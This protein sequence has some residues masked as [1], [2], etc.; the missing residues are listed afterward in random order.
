MRTDTLHRTPRVIIGVAL[1]MITP[2]ALAQN[3]DETAIGTAD[4]VLAEP[5]LP[6]PDTQPCVVHLFQDE[7]FGAKG[8]NKR[9]DSLPHKYTY[10]PPADCQGPWS[11]VVLEADFSVD[12]GSQYDRTASIWLDGVNIYFGTTQEPV[13][14]YGPDWHIERDLTDYSALLRKPGKGAARINNWVDPRH[15]SKIHLDAKLVFYPANAQFPAPRTADQVVALNTKNA[16]AKLQTG[17]QTLA[18]T[19]TFPRDVTRAYLDVLAQ[20]QFHDEYWFTCMPKKYVKRTM[21]FAIP[22]GYLGAPKIPEACAGGNFREAEVSIDG[23]PAGLAPIFPWIYTGGLDRLL[24][25]PSASVQT[26]NFLPYRVDLSPFAGELADGQPHKVSVR[27]IGANQYFSVAASLLVYRDPDGAQTRGAV[28]VNTLAN[29]DLTP[30]VTS[31]LGD[32]R[33]DLNGQLLTRA[34]QGYT[35]AGYVDSSAGRVE[36][37]VSQH[38]TFANT[39]RFKTVDA[40]THQQTTNLSTHAVSVSQQ[41]GAAGHERTSRNAYDFTLRSNRRLHDDADGTHSKAMRV[42][43]GFQKHFMYRVGDEKPYWGN[44][45]NT[46]TSSNK[47]SYKRTADSWTSTNHGQSGQQRFSYNDSLHGCY[48][49]EVDSEDGNV[50]NVDRVPSC[51]REPM[52]WFARP[53]GSPASFGWRGHAAAH[54]DG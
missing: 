33:A 49:A 30:T 15:V 52:P 28:T 36:T 23:T 5:A 40:N 34:N 53:D 14:D 47:M 18:R 35:I 7:S 27:V 32:N 12:A 42:D 1:M 48:F 44:I 17:E 4:V 43:Q 39:Q 10:T 11:K 31:T 20:S 6:R 13:K 54:K 25:R 50:T 16:P 37:R 24:W 38:I 2:L 21:S 26:L 46:F 19:I 9:M 22:R 41:S 8:G 51:G 45:A 3:Q 29:M